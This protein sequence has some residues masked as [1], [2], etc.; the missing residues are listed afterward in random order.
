MNSHRT[1]APEFTPNFELLEDIARTLQVSSESLRER[2]CPDRAHI[3]PELWVRVHSHDLSP[4][5]LA[6]LCRNITKQNHSNPTQNPSQI[7]LRPLLK[8]LQEH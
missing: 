3:V 5:A 1:R 4:A 7:G 2:L 8:E 6:E